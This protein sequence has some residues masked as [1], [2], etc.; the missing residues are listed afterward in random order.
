M[1]DQAAGRLQVRK[2]APK[3]VMA[4]APAQAV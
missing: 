3:A 1:R 4:L 2:G